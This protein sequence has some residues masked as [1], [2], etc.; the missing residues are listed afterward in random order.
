MSNSVSRVEREQKFLVDVDEFMKW[1]ATAQLLSCRV[2]QCYLALDRGDGGF[3]VRLRATEDL[4][5]PRG[6]DPFS[7]TLTAKRRRDV[8]TDRDEVEWSATEADFLVAWAAS[9]WR[10]EKTRYASGALGE[11]QVDVFR[12]G[13]L[14]GVAVAELEFGDC[15]NMHDALIRQGQIFPLWLSRQPGFK[16]SYSFIDLTAERV[17]LVAAGA[18]TPSP[19][20]QRILDA[21]RQ[22]RDAAAASLQRQ[23]TYQATPKNRQGVVDLDAAA[24]RRKGVGR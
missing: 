21:D 14:D 3:E 2:R 9:P 5:A 7:Y 6:F 8:E 23:D 17:N 16:S 11:W 20:L 18:V 22:R 19:R 12:G 1:A 10:V 13:A 4:S 15:G 24:R